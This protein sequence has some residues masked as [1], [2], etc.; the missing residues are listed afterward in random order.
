MGFSGRFLCRPLVLARPLRG[1]TLCAS[2]CPLLDRRCSFFANSLGDSSLKS[3]NPCA[4]SQI[5]EPRQL[6]KDSD[7]RPTRKRDCLTKASSDFTQ[8]KNVAKKMPS[9]IG[10]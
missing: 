2:W 4:Q 7:R 9:G 1:K 8:M 5:Q 3:R 10:H 6:S